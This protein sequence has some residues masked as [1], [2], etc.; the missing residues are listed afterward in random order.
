MKRT[1][2]YVKVCKRPDRLVHSS[3]RLTQPPGSQV[4]HQILYSSHRRTT[5]SNQG[6]TDLHHCKEQQ[7]NH[8]ELPLIM[9]RNLHSKR[10][11]PRLQ[12]FHGRIEQEYHTVDDR[13]ETLSVLIRPALPIPSNRD[14]VDRCM[15]S[16]DSSPAMNKSPDTPPR[17]PRRNVPGPA[18]HRELK[19]SRQ[20]RA[21]QAY[22][23]KRADQDAESLFTSQRHLI[24]TPRNPESLLRESPCLT[25]LRP[26]DHSH[27]ATPS[28]R[29]GLFKDECTR[30]KAPPR[31]PRYSQDLEFREHVDFGFSAQRK[32]YFEAAGA[33]RGNHQVFTTLQAQD[34]IN[35]HKH[36][37]KARPAQ[38]CDMKSWYIGACERTKAEQALYLNKQ[39]GVFLVR[40]HSKT[41]EEEP[42]VLAVLQDDKV[43]NIKI[44]FLKSNQKF[45]LGTGLRTNDMFDSVED[46]I[47]FH[48]IFPINLI[49]GKDQ[50]AC[51]RRCT[52]TYPLTKE[53][54]TQLLG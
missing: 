16:K 21:Q 44:R 38:M 27:A 31:M 53:K 37:R 47:K 7:R 48:T 9:E 24:W 32:N 41:T 28:P 43:Y 20:Q 8:N 26:G 4:L 23:K 52:L 11:E 15:S 35:V 40:D 51:N 18:V 19:P 1:D 33:H 49:N 50:S 13:E 2:E 45:A 54:M 5:E 6:H 39:D 17:V 34:D 42:F 22:D 36:I 14:Y 29:G 46:I 10:C 12:R 3:S 30:S 25:S